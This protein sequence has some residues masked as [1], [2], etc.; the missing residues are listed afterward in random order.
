MANISIKTKG[1][2]CGSC[3]MLVK[4]ALEELNGVGNVEASHK[5]GNV[6]VE[7][8]KIIVKEQEIKEVIKKEGFGV[9]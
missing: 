6:Y 5:T 4:D 3:E 1:M 9:E 2:H 8:D 7:F